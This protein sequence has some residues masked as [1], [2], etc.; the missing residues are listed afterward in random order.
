MYLQYESQSALV[1][2]RHSLGFIML[3]F[4]NVR[5]RL[6]KPFNSTTKGCHVMF[7]QYETQSA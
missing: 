7:L 6:L 3:S 2:Q 1:I 5:H 4:F